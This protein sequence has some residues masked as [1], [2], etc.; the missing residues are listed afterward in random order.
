MKSILIGSHF[1]HR[2]AFKGCF[3][4][5]QILSKNDQILVRQLDNYQNER[6]A[7]SILNAK[8]FKVKYKDKLT[9]RFLK[10]IN[11]IHNNF[12]LQNIEHLIIS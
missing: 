1:Y 2:S 5:T 8:N 10:L 9:K 4:Q 11:T 7:Y 3:Y 12:H 6:K